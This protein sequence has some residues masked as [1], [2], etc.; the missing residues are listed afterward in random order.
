MGS[1]N[2]VGQRQNICRSSDVRMS[3]T[4]YS[5][6]GVLLSLMNDEHLYDFLAKINVKWRAV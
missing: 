4:K 2:I 1:E 5:R 3:R 6:T